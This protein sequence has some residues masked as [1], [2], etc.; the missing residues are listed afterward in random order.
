MTNPKKGDIR[1][2]NGVMLR[3]LAFSD[4]GYVMCRHACTYPE[5]LPLCA[6]NQLQKLPEQ[7]RMAA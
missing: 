2:R 6:W 5:I 4:D 7:V 3:C 1:I